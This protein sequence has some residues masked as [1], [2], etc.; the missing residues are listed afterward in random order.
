[1]AINFRDKSLLMP[2]QV[3]AYEALYDEKYAFWIGPVNKKKNRIKHHQMENGQLVNFAESVDARL[4]GDKAESKKYGASL[5]A[6]KGELNTLEKEHNQLQQLNE[7][8]RQIELLK[9]QITR[10]QQASVGSANNW[11]A[12]N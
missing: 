1:M 7:L 5:T 3:G 10:F 2:P 12:N 6:L 11:D 8:Q 4:I 9:Q